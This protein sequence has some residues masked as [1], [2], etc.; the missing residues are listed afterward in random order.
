MNSISFFSND[1]FNVIKSKGHPK[2]IISTIVRKTKRRYLQ[3]PSMTLRNEDRLDFIITIM[4]THF[5]RR[6]KLKSTIE[7]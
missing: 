6:M 7:F 4:R 1:T 2:A 3:I 5:D